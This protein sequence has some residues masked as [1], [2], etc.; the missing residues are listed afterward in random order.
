MLSYTVIS[1]TRRTHEIP[2]LFGII[3]SSHFSTMNGEGSIPQVTQLC[4]FKCSISKEN[5]FACMLE[6]L[7]LGKGLLTEKQHV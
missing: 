7:Y 4:V 3:F 5:N 6:I 1:N 2:K